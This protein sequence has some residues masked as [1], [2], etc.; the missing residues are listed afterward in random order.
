MSLAWKIYASAGALT[1]LVLLLGLLSVLALSLLQQ[2]LDQVVHRDAR[3]SQMSA[4]AG[5]T[6]GAILNAQRGVLLGSLTGDAAQVESAS[7]QLRD[8]ASRLRQSLRAMEPL[9]AEE[10]ERNLHAQMNSTVEDWQREYSKWDSNIRGQRF[11][12]ASKAQAEV[13]RPIFDRMLSKAEELSSAANA[14]Q[15]RSAEASTSQV[16]LWKLVSALLCLVSLAIGAVV[17]WVIHGNAAELSRIAG[18]IEEGSRQVASAAHQVSGSSQALAQGSS[19]QA[20]TLEETSASTEELNSMTQKNAENART[21][22]TESDRADQ[23]LKAT[24]QKLGE[25]ITSMRE[26]NTSSE[27]IS[28]IIRV[29]DEIAFQTNILALNAA[30]EAARAGQAGMGF[31]VVADEVR[32]LAQRSAQAARDTSELIEESIQRSGE[33]KLRLD[34]VAACVANVFE[35]SS[36]IRVLFNEVNL[37]SQEQARGIEQISRSVSQMQQVTQSTAASAEQSAS[38]GEQ[39]SAQAQSLHDSVERLRLLVNGAAGSTGPARP[40]MAAA[41]P[42]LGLLHKTSAR[43]G[44]QAPAHSAIPMGDFKDF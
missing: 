29:I 7:R 40:H 39:M 37:G 6:A 13:F 25:M 27:K 3:K 20:A 14:A 17:F 11:D 5:A 4:E 32:N 38:A 35:N 8:S 28:R 23:L 19:E 31:A 15:A 2:R 34:E 41:R 44:W 42:D 9:L 33:G 22:A 24:D 1:S 43:A 30:V 10:V 21:A 26:I 36:R 18:E 16:S 12:E